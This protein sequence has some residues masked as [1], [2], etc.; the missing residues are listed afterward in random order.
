MNPVLLRF[1][2]LGIAECM[3]GQYLKPLPFG[4]VI[5][6]V[7]GQVI[8]NPCR[9]KQDANRNLCTLQSK[10]HVR[11]GYLKRQP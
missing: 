9:D 5:C 11:S 1:R 4:K 8:A 7:H 10:L 2:F 3:A 6:T